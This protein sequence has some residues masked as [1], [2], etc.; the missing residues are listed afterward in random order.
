MTEQEKIAL[1]TKI[2]D[3]ET[4]YHQL[5]IGS[6]P[7]VI[8]DQNGERVEFTAVNRLALYQYIASLKRLLPD[9]HLAPV[10]KPLGFL[11]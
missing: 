1:R 11:F 7:R 6:M 10:N 2:A 4:K 9:E 5:M 8:V 3:A